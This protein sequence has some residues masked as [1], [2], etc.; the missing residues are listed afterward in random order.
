MLAVVRW[1]RRGWSKKRCAGGAAGF[2]AVVGPV[3]I[4][5]AIAV[6]FS[7]SS[8]WAE[9][10]PSRATRYHGGKQPS[11][12]P[13]SELLHMPE[14]Q[15]DRCREFL[16]DTIRQQIDFSQ[17]DQQMGVAPRRWKSRFQTTP[18]GSIC[19]PSDS[20]KGLKR[21]T[22]R[23]P[24]AA[25]AAAAASA[26]SRSPSMSWPSCSGRRRECRQQVAPGAV[27]RTVPSAGNRHALETYIAALRVSGL[28]PDLYRYLPLE[29]QLLHLFHETQMPGS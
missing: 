28:E 14:P 26:P 5:V 20:G 8:P 11:F 23:R 3:A 16:K 6:A 12:R 21:W 18:A 4:A 19:R 17:T 10:W 9:N 29:H 25:A 24:W 2:A 15:L 1:R 7:L 22:W 13:R 27:L